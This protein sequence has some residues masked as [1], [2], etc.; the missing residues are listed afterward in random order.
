MC[1]SRRMVN[2]PNISSKT[3][4]IYSNHLYH[5]KRDSKQIRLI[6]L[7]IGELQSHFRF[8]NKYLHRHL[9]Y[10]TLTILIY[11]H[12]NERE[13]SPDS[14]VRIKRKVNENRYVNVLG[15][16]GL[17]KHNKVV[18]GSLTISNSHMNH[19]EGKR[20]KKSTIQI[21]KNHFILLMMSFY[22]KKYYVK[23]LILQLLQWST[24]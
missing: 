23:H 16:N 9:S 17:R 5:Y 10:I 24:W 21:H 3:K 13:Y 19:S 11:H 15:G 6:V 12:K 14:W 1:S 4:N 7:G 8:P 18:D 20:K 22:T 2:M